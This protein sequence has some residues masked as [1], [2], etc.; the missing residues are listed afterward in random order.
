M[1]RPTHNQNP[2]NQVNSFVD[3]LCIIYLFT[4]YD[5]TETNPVTGHVS[6]VNASGVH[7]RLGDSEEFSDFIPWTN[8]K[9]VRHTS[10]LLSDESAPTLDGQGTILTL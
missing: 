2:N 9:S 1:A 3:K 6:D 5:E 10:P 4:A 7:L 8:I